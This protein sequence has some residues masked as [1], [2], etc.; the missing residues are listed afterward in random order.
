MADS[1]GLRKFEVAFNNYVRFVYS[2]RRYDH[3]SDYNKSILG[4]SLSKSYEFRACCMLFKTINTFSMK[5]FSSTLHGGDLVFCVWQR[6]ATERL[7]LF[8][9][10]TFGTI[11][12]WRWGAVLLWI[13]WRGVVICFL[14]VVLKSSRSKWSYARYNMFLLYDC[15]DK[16]E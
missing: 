2:L 9:S 14:P 11:Y 3:I 12:L 6:L 15:C 7:F 1:T 13:F 4:Y 10:F 8:L 5:I 16:R